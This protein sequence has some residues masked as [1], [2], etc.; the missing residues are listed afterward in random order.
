M[1]QAL[2]GG[3]L[4]FPSLLIV[5]VDVAGDEDSEHQA[6]Q[7]DRRDGIIPQ[8]A[9]RHQVDQPADIQEQEGHQ[10]VEQEDKPG[11]ADLIHGRSHTQ[12][13]AV[14]FEL[15][16]HTSQ[17]HQ[18]KQNDDGLDWRGKRQDTP[19]MPGNKSLH[20]Q[21]DCQCNYKEFSHSGFLLR[22]KVL[23]FIMMCKESGI[24]HYFC[25]RFR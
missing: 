24:I 10:Q 23:F 4:Y 3:E 7:N 18:H 25:H 6:R 16:H 14:A 17:R 20:D 21:N 15:Q 5:V 22:A 8:P 2:I 19:H 9:A 1:L 13:Q 11:I 12:G